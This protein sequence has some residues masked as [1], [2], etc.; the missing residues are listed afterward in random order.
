MSLGLERSAW[1]IED[2][3]QQARWYVRRAGEPVATRY[4]AALDQS[5]ELLT[6]HPGLGRKRRFRHPRLR[7]IRSY[8]VKPPFHKHLIFYWYGA[9]VLYAERVIHGARDLP[10]RLLE[11]PARLARKHSIFE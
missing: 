1:F 5:L 6:R 9:A 2:F 8:R 10:R 3:E 7:G 11:P 4:L